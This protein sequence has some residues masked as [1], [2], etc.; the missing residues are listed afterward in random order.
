ME[1]KSYW[2]FG[3]HEHCVLHKTDNIFDI[4]DF[5]CKELTKY[6]EGNVFGI[7]DEI[8]RDG[9]LKKTVSVIATVLQSVSTGLPETIETICLFPIRKTHC[10]RGV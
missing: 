1:Y 5:Q 4:M 6:T 9:S 7:F 8:K 3:E 2:G 10:Q